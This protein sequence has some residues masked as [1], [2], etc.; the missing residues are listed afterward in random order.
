MSRVFLP[1]AG[2]DVLLPLYDPLWRLFGGERRRADF[3]RDA[4]IAS[5]QRI[6]DVGCGTG[7]LLVQIAETVK[8]TR[9]SGLDPDGKALVRCRQKAARAGVDIDWCEG[10]ADELPHA[11]ASFDRVLSSFMFHHLDLDV[12][13][14]ML[15]EVRRVLTPGGEFHLIDFGG[16]HQGTHAALARLF[17]SHT[18]LA[19]NRAGRVA[20]LFEEAGFDD[21]REVS[22]HR[23]VLG[24]YAHVR[25]VAG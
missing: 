21:I 7:S 11:D 9:L 6:L 25:G 4:G 10:F 22:Q 20:A 13:Q 23:S 3:I 15:R 16:Q 24:S 1:A 2:L 19:D 8:G 18:Q 14:G 12:K 17:H 5:G